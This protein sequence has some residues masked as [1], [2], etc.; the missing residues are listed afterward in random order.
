MLQSVSK[1]FCWN[2]CYSWCPFTNVTIGLIN[3]LLA[4][5]LFVNTVTDVTIG[6]ISSLLAPLL[7]VNT[8]TDIQSVFSVCRFLSFNVGSLSNI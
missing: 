1:F 6:L 4:T 8:V 7:F 5:L 2:H 3:Y